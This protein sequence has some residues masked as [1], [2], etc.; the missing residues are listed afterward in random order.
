MNKWLKITILSISVLVVGISLMAFRPFA[1]HA[2]EDGTADHTAALADALGISVEELEAAFQAVHTKMVE[3]AVSDG[4]MTQEQADKMLEQ[5]APFPGSRIK[6]PGH[7]LRG[8]DFNTLLAEEL[9]IDLDTLQK[10]QQTAQESMLAQALADG[11]ITQDVYDN[12][13]AQSKMR[14]YYQDAFS[15]AYQNAIKAALADGAITEAQ[16]ET[17]LENAPEFGF[18]FGRGF[19]M[20][21]FDRGPGGPHPFHGPRDSQGD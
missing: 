14:P 20:P 3:Q 2:T 13:L 7:F 15:E 4:L 16:A 12:M 6:F 1:D 18:G 19:G 8:E 21:M 10:A 9:G 17:L 5:E 11:N